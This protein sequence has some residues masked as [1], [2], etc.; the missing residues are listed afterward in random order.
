MKFAKL[1]INH[2]KVSDSVAVHTFTVLC[3]HHLCLVP[4]HFFF[5][6]ATP[7][8]WH[9]EALRLGIESELQLLAYPT[10]HGSAGSLTH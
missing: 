5:F 6:K 7:A 4:R 10:A 8:P 9:M 1:K 3:N 2:L